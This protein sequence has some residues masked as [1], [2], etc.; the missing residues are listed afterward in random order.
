MPVR[1]RSRVERFR[2]CH[3]CWGGERQES[4]GGYH[5][6]VL[7]SFA[8]KII[9]Q[10]RVW[11]GID[12][13]KGRSATLKS[14]ESKQ[15]LS[16]SNDLRTF[17]TDV[18]LSCQRLRIPSAAASIPLRRCSE[19]RALG[20]VVLSDA[21]AQRARTHAA[22][23]LDDEARLDGLSP[24]LSRP[25]AVVGSAANVVHDDKVLAMGLGAEV[26]QICAGDFKRVTSVDK[27]AGAA[28][29]VVRVQVR[30]RSE[31]LQERLGAVS[32]DQKMPT[33]QAG[34]TEEDREERQRA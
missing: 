31:P 30:R 21:V 5:G 7:S 15:Q 4:I 18:P 24:G 17:C 6:C 27:D 1:T 20:R 11:C 23:G 10:L 25:V 32:N 8:S 29:D 34:N 22:V 16:S 12:Y 33:W 3:M 19:G 28:I 2:S 13:R 14:L 9:P 26:A